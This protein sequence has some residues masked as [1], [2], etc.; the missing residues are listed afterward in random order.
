MRKYLAD[1]AAR[2][3][4]RKSSRDYQRRRRA[5]PGFNIAAANEESRAKKFGITVPQLRALLA[6]GCCSICGSTAPGGRHDE[7][8]VDHDHNTGAVRTILCNGCNR[9]LGFFSDDPE[10]LRAAAAYLELHRV[11]A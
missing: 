3:R 9:G 8:H 6:A 1:P 2:E 7:W 5:A 11:L 4:A 10:R